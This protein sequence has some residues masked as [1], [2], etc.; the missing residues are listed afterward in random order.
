MNVYT[1]T[2]ILYDHVGDFVS[3]LFSQ[4]T[5]VLHRA[6]CW[7]HVRDDDCRKVQRHFLLCVTQAST[8][9]VGHPTFSPQILALGRVQVGIMLKMGRS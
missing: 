1:A 8:I 6:C 2:A 5:V 3:V 9:R 4:F 7:E